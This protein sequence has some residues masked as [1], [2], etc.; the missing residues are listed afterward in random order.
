V[1]LCGLGVL[2]IALVVVFFLPEERLRS[3]SGIQARRQE[4]ADEMAAAAVSAQ[5]AG[6]STASSQMVDGDT[7]SHEGDAID[8]DGEAV[9]AD[10]A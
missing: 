7:I 4:E 8:H 5:A 1:F 2:S 10:R 9:T 6:R 3:M